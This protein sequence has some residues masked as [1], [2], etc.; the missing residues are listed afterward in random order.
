M[1][2]TAYSL[3]GF[4][5][6]TDL[7]DKKRILRRLAMDCKRIPLECSDKGDIDY[8]FLETLRNNDIDLRVKQFGLKEEMYLSIHSAEIIDP[9]QLTQ[10]YDYDDIQDFKNTLKL[11]GQ[12]CDDIKPFIYTIC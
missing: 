8:I 2:N 11:L 1:V 3:F 6:N 5:L 4:K 10:Y 7:I 12:N 9:L